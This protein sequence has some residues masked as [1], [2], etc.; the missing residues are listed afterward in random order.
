MKQK[1]EEQMN[2]ILQVAERFF[3]NEFS[4]VLHECGSEIEQKL[5]SVPGLLI[6][7]F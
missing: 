5:A 2:N 7:I 3:L 6:S 1:F 4:D